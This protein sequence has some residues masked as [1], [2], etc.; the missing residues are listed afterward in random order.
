MAAYPMARYLRSVSIEGFVNKTSVLPGERLDF[1]VSMRDPGR[2]RIDIYRMGYYGGLGGR[3][4][5]TLG[6]FQ[7]R[8]QEDP[9]MT[10]ERLRECEWETATS[11][12]IPNDWP[13]GVYLGKLSI[14]EPFGKQSYVIFVV[15]E[16]RKSD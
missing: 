5:A 7:G 1:K 9:M 16:N 11:F 10:V 6:T 4:M 15:R 3:H 14:D 12:T 8:R 2:F 13:S